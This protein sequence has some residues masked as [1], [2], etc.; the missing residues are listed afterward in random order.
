M[1]KSCFTELLAPCGSFE[2]L[3]AALRAGAD[4]VYVGGKSFSARQNATNF[5]KDELFEAVRECHRFGAKI[6]QAINTAVTDAEL[7]T[8]ADEIK[9]AC[10]VGIDGIITQDLACV[11]IVSQACPAMPLHA[12][13][14]M[15]LHTKNGVLWAKEQGFCRVVVSRELSGRTI[16]ELSAL[17]IETEAFV[18]G[19]LCMSVSGQ[20]YLSALIGSR[21]ANRGLCAGA[22]RLPFSAN[23]TKDKYALSLKDMSQIDFADEMRENGVA[24]LKIE[25]RMKRPE[26]VA[27]ATHALRSVLDGKPYDT[28]LLE[29]SFSRSGFTSGYYT[30]NLGEKMF[31][32]RSHQDVLNMQASL[33]EL[34]ELYKTEPKKFEI[35]FKF[36][37]ELEKAVCLTACDGTN[38]VTVWGAACEKAINR[39]L[40]KEAVLTQL[41]K[42][43]GTLYSLKNAEISIG[44]GIS[45]PISAINALRRDAI[46]ALDAKRI[47]PLTET[48]PFN[49]EKLQLARPLTLNNKIPELRL[50]VQKISQLEKVDTESFICIIPLSEAENCIKKG[51]EPEN[52][53]LSLPRFTFDEDAMIQKLE[54]AKNLGFKAVECTN[55]AHIRIAKSLEMRAL[56]G[57][58]LNISNSLSAHKLYE[59][60]VEEIILSFELKANQLSQISSPTPTGAIIYGNLPLMLNANCPIMAEVGCKNCTGSLTDRTGEKFKILCHKD[61]GYY[62]LLNCKTLW[63]ADKLDD[64]N[65]DFG[66]LY[67]TTE[68][69][70]QVA[71]VLQKYQDRQAPSGDFTRGLYYRG[72]MNKN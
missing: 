63:L 43:G 37:A 20:C 27:A 70:E 9:T 47:D 67:F 61:L 33:S 10:E 32:A 30:E 6:Y 52:F 13:T 72:G 7:Q 41:S 25:G 40:E 46:S 42:L 14:Q 55:Y 34:K 1:N 26:Y 66:T 22:C 2:A 23:G 28:E 64:F 3:I 12:S 62:E 24:S 59:C 45:L 48:K 44:E 5:T 8:L 68:T 54:T 35:E 71:S 21:S 53:V 4:A 16:K 60:G 15:T 56:G 49:A 38:E 50:S 58:G 57:F 69:A 11:E 31:G 36:S 18:H 39:P 17:E 51:Y 19:A 65:I 29:A